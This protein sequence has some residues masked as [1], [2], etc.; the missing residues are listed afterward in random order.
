MKFGL[1]LGD[2]LEDAAVL[3]TREV[4]E[5]REQLLRAYVAETGL[6]PTE[7]RMVEQTRVSDDPRAVGVGSM[8][9]CEP[10]P[11]PPGQLP[12][13]TPRE[14]C[15]QPGEPAGLQLCVTTIEEGVELIRVIA[16]AMQELA[17]HPG[18]PCAVGLRGCLLR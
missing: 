17:K 13:F 8:V 1:D 10:L 15:P 4:M 6:Y 3:L 7:C 2:Y 18:E 16:R 11:K 12:R 5:K 9:W 14:A